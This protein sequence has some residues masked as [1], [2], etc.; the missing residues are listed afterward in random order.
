MK[1]KIARVSEQNSENG[2]YSLS[3]YLVAQLGKNYKDKS[4][5]L[6]TGKQLLNLAIQ[7]IKELQYMVGGMVVFLETE[8]TEKLIY[9]YEVQNQFKKFDVREVRK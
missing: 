6:I 3:A 1:K 9:F 4:N 5:E 7:K 8:N 2:N